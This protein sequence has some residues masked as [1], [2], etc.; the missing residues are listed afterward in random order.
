MDTLRSQTVTDSADRQFQDFLTTWSLWTAGACSEEA[1]RDL[2]DAIAEN[3]WVPTPTKESLALR[4]AA[5]SARRHSGLESPY[6]SDEVARLAVAHATAIKLGL[7]AWIETYSRTPS[8][9]YAV[10]EPFIS[11]GRYD[12]ITSAA[13]TYAGRADRADLD[14]LA[15]LELATSYGRR[16]NTDFLRDVRFHEADDIAGADLIVTAYK[17]SATNNDRRRDLLDAWGVLQPTSLT[18]RQRLID[19]VTLPMLRDGGRKALDHVK[20]RIALVANPVDRK[21]ALRDALRKAVGG[22]DKDKKLESLIVEHGITM[23]RKKGLFGLSKEEV[24]EG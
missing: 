1:A 21:N 8:E 5:R 4:V 16:I 3:S 17:Q 18:A 13:R 15:A 11:K 14:G 22:K 9:V 19:N 10:V 23:Q 2:T 12:D 20:S 7:G 6:S 24:D